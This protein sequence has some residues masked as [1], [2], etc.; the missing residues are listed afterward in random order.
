MVTNK[1]SSCMEMVDNNCK[2][3]VVSLMYE[4]T[5]LDKFFIFSS[6]YSDSFSVIDP[7]LLTIGHP[8]LFAL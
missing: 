3:C 2:K 5:S 6:T 4:G 8:G 1:S 7:M